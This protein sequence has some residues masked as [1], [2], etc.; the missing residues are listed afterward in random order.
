MVDTSQEEEAC[1]LA[2]L[3]FAITSAGHVTAMRKRGRGSLAAQS[4]DD[5]LQVCQTCSFCCE[6]DIIT[7]LNLVVLDV[8]RETLLNSAIV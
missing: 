8:E 3:V 4:I 6:I 7:V 5:M 1:S 2:C